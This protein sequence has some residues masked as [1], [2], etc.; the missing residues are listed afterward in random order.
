MFLCYKGYLWAVQQAI[1]RFCP[2]IYGTFFLS[3]TLLELGKHGDR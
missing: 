1:Q 3:T 2:L